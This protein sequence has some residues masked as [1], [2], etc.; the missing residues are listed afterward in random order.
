MSDIMNSRIAAIAKLDREGRIV[1][2]S[3]AFCVLLDRQAEEVV[4]HSFREFTIGLTDWFADMLAADLPDDDGIVTQD[5][6]ISMPSGE[7]FWVRAVISLAA[8]D[9]GTLFPAEISLVEIEDLRQYGNEQARQVALLDRM[10]QVVDS[11][12]WVSGMSDGKNLYVSPAY[13]RIWGTGCNQLE[14]D[15]GSWMAQIHPDDRDR[16]ETEVRQQR[17]AR[18]P[19]D[20]EYRIIRND[21]S[22]RWIWD[23]G[24]PAKNLFRNVD[25]YIGSA[26]DIT[27]RKVQEIELARRQ[28]ADNI[29]M[30]A[31]DLAH[32]FHNLLAIVDLAAHAIERADQSATHA[33]RLESIHSAVE[34][35]SE[36]TK[37]LL[38]ISSRQN[39]NPSHSD[40]NTVVTE[41]K[42]LVDASMGINHR[43]I[44]DLSNT[45][46][47]VHIDR[48]GLSQALLNLIKNS[49]EAMPASGELLVQTRVLS[50]AVLSDGEDTPQP[51]V[52]ITIEDTGTGMS[53]HALRHATDPYFTTKS[54]GSGF[55]LAI[56]NGFV[57]QSGGRL[58]L[59]NKIGGGLI[60]RMVFPLAAPV[61]AA[62][63]LPGTAAV[64]QAKSLL[65]VDDE[66]AI[67]KTLGQLLEAE[68]YL[69]A[70]ATDIR[71]ARRQLDKG[72]FDAL[73]SDIALGSKSTGADLALWVR[74]RHPSVKLVLMSGYASDKASIPADIPFITKPFAPADLIRTVRRELEDGL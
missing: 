36:I 11:V 17:A 72:G 52:Q 8:A 39:L 42:P 51:C 47:P 24:M 35:G 34:R 26:Q 58:F 32:N 45:P 53:E 18:R 60:A 20:V 14:S 16:V 33:E 5:F 31:A 62:D 6:Q 15:A 66:M 21:G 28:A 70:I 49:R 50:S 74:A 30:M 7:I 12:F 23:K 68:G 44:Y 25:V 64:F 13:E 59:E 3:P 46:C 27:D 43:V 10:L 63:R 38:T 57:K 1:A 40:L 37:L 54:N 55:G 29:N 71:E 22:M 2:A 61:A 56:T 73:I 48:T 4:G 67:A 65:V 19:F 9:N 69:T 41:M